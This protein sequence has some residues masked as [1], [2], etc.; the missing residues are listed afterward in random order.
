MTHLHDILTGGV[1]RHADRVAV[2]FRDRK[3]TYE[4][5]LLASRIMAAA[6]RASGLRPGDRVA[7]LDE[8]SLEYPV[9]VFAVSLIGAVFVPV[10]FRY[11]PDEVA[12][13]VNDSAP[14]LLLVSPDY[15]ARAEQASARF[16]TDTR[17]VALESAEALLAGSVPPARVADD[18]RDAP[19]MIMYTSGT[20][21]FPKGALISH[22]AYL[23]NVEAI[24]NAGELTGD[25]RLL[26]SLPLFHNGG[27]IALLMP[28]L[29][30]GAPAVI[31]PRGFDPDHVM[32]LVER[33]RITVTMWVPTMLAMILEAG[34]TERHDAS[35]LQR[36]WYGSSPIA[37]ELFARVR[38]AF[39][40]RL[41][42]FYG[43]TETG[44]TAVLTP[45][46]HA[47]HPQG[48]GKAMAPATLRIVDGS[49]ADVPDGAVGELIS[50]QAPLG[51]LG[52]L[53]NDEAT[54]E[55]VRDGW[56]H[57]GDM[58]RNLGD[59]YFL[60][61][62]RKTDMIISGAENIYPREIENVLTAH[63][64]VAE[65]AVFGIPDPVYGEAVC[66]AVVYVEGADLREA[67]LIAH[68][69]ERLAGYKKPKRVIAQDALPRNAAG[70]VMKTVLR[71]PF[72]QERERAI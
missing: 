42:Q 14:R 22:A 2:I 57:T 67:D 21:G 46:D 34:A 4:Q 65:A 55:T 8:N 32:S 11:S 64:Q 16:R 35:S 9:V 7:L 12:Y 68:C 31:L 24:A 51:M 19:A 71:A 49:G 53:G 30:R 38:A 45:D 27:L 69:G 1:A 62:D 33:H 37:P 25:D 63:P 43:M 17:I 39:G 72:W 59:G 3:L 28:A 26:V 47:I 56:I 70:K 13:V 36:I 18:S 15:E 23:A 52:Y 10:N 6:L 58:A 66:A 50:K 60:L 61:V 5:L 20:T 40:A 29:S 48:T 54:R 44:M 41:Y